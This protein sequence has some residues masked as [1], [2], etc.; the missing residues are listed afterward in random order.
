M[1]L[2]DVI[3][4][5]TSWNKAVDKLLFMFD[6][7]SPARYKLYM[8]AL[9]I[10]IMYDQRIEKPEGNEDEAKSTI[11]RNVFFTHDNGKLDLMFQ[12]AILSS[13]TVQYTEEERLAY[14]FGE[15]SDLKNR[16]LQISTSMQ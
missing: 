15:K 6:S 10:G 16:C 8:L 4:T 5:G 14:A 11:G 7:K 9:S 3:L 1:E 2:S 13:A 12:A